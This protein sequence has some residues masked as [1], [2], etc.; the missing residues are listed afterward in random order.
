MSS[1]LGPLGFSVLYAQNPNYKTPITQAERAGP[2]GAYP[3]GN[4]VRIWRAQR[5][6]V[7]QVMRQ[8]KTPE[9]GLAE[10]VKTTRELLGNS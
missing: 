4:S 3:G 9:D 2:W 5:D 6:I 1:I 8:K 10:I 7:G